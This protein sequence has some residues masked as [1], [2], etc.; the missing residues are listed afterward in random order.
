MCIVISDTE[1]HVQAL[2]PQCLFWASGVYSRLVYL[3]DIRCS[4]PYN[5]EKR[6]GLWTWKWGVEHD[7]LYDPVRWLEI[8]FGA[9][10]HNS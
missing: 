7:S 6:A 1:I 4:F 3:L 9:T 5:V 8:D 10:D 2:Q